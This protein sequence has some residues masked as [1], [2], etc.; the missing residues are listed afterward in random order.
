MKKIFK[1]AVNW[2]KGKPQILR[3]KKDNCK[4]LL[5][6]ECLRKL[7]L[8]DIVTVMKIKNKLLSLYVK[9]NKV[10]VGVDLIN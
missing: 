4:Y 3:F 1:W 10:M 8:I 7:L 6:K 9:C 2:T 5:F